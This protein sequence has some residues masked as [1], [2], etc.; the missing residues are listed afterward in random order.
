MINYFRPLLLFLGTIFAISTLQWLLM[1]IY[2]H[3]CLDQTVYG[4]FKNMITMGNPICNSL[5]KIQSILLDH[6]LVYV[7]AGIL[8]V[9]SYISNFINNI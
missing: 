7:A 9:S 6:Y 3:Y 2:H 1:I 4:I 5:N 8:S